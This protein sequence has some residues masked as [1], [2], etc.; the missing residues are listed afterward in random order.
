M[1][2]IMKDLKGI[3]SAI[4]SVDD[5]LIFI[6]PISKVF[7]TILVYINS[8]IGLKEVTFTIL[9]FLEILTDNSVNKIR[10]CN[11]GNNYIYF[12]QLFLMTYFSY[13]MKS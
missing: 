13:H 11:N 6:E 3:I 8:H 4:K 10:A 2:G 5:F 1:L 9:S 7:P 12:K